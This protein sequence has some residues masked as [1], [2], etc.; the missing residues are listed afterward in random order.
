MSCPDN[1]CPTTFSQALILVTAGF[2]LFS[3]IIVL[4]IPA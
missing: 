3:V 2:T 4:A 1:T